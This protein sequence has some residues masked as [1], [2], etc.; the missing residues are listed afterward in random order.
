MAPDIPNTGEIGYNIP[1]ISILYTKVAL[2]LVQ[3][4]F[5]DLFGALDNGINL[6]NP[7]QKLAQAPTDNLICE[8]QDGSSSWSMGVWGQSEIS[9]SHNDSTKPTYPPYDPL[10]TITRSFAT[11]SFT[12]LMPNG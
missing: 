7:S 1:Q 11:C 3:Q 8:V 2:L 4:Q 10:Q 9:P 6:L 5:Y 12:R